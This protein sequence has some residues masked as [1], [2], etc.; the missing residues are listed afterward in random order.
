MDREDWKIILEILITGEEAA[1]TVSKVLFTRDD[2][3][4]E[5]RGYEEGFFGKVTKL[6]KIVHK[7]SRYDIERTVDIIEDET[8]SIDEK[9]DMLF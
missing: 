7:Y 4:P 6:Y 8:L 5:A 1:Y 9:V 2:S 3:I